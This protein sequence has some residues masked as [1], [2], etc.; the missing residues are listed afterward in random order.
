MARRLKPK[1]TKVAVVDRGANPHADIVFYKSEGAVDD[2]AQE[3]PNV[4]E[5]LVADNEITQEQLDEL[6]SANDKLQAE[7]DALGAM[8]PEEVAALLGLELAKRDE[9]EEVLKSLPEDVRKRIEESEEKVAKMEAEMRKRDFAAKAAEYAHVG[10]V[11]EVGTLLDEA[12]RNLSAEVNKTLGMVLKAAEARIA[13]SGLFKTLGAESA[14]GSD[15]NEAAIQ[16]LMSDGLSRTDAIRKHFSAN[17][18]AYPAA[19]RV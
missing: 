3:A 9:S 16:K 14:E 15:E 5:P 8:S 19:D 18:D 17:P 6:K 10:S 11:D 4:K 1:I 12:D 7:L 2:E 13:E